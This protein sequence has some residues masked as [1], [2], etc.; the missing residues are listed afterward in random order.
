MGVEPLGGTNSGVGGVGSTIYDSLPT[1]RG[2]KALAGSLGVGR[3]VAAA[4]GIVL[5]RD[6]RA[7]ERARR[8]GGTARSPQ[9][10]V[11]R[12]EW[13]RVCRRHSYCRLLCAGGG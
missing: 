9:V 12:G 1:L 2:G 10:I 4:V 11:R 13:G 3:V 5:S 6:T 7:G 8:R